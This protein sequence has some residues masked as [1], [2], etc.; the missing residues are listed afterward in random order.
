MSPEY[1]QPAGL[2]PKQS[3]AAASLTLLFM[4]GP[5]RIPAGYARCFES[6]KGHTMPKARFSLATLMHLV[7]IC[8]VAFW[9]AGWW[10]QANQLRQ[11]LNKAQV[12]VRIKT[13]ENEV[14]LG[15]TTVDKSRAPRYPIMI[16]LDRSQ[17]S[18]KAMARFE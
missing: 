14:I 2:V 8:G 1:N 12:Q 17:W 4:A 9:G 3:R 16:A 11:E 18:H 10:H 7:A 5:K 6:T 15:G 13:D